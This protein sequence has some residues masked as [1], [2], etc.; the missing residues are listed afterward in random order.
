MML[1]E[2]LIFAAKHQ[3]TPR[4][5]LFFLAVAIIIGMIAVIDSINKTKYAIWRNGLPYCPRCGMQISL[6]ASRTH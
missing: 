4:V 6:K 5:A 2:V 3:E 1:S